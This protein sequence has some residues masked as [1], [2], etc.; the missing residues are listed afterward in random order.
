[1]SLGKDSLPTK[2]F[3]IK[4]IDIPGAWGRDANSAPAPKTDPAIEQWGYNNLNPHYVDW[5]L[6]KLFTLANSKLTS[7]FKAQK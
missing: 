1:M 4:T 2:I 5:S 3:K 6:D 7:G